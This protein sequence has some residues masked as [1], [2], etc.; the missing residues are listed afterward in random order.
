MNSVC[1][2]IFSLLSLWKI[3]C[4]TADSESQGELLPLHITLLKGLVFHFLSISVSLGLN[5]FVHF[6]F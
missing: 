5:N 2:F 1:L 4:G 6:C 3:K